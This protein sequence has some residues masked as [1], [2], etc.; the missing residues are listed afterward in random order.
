MHFSDL[1]LSEPIL[2]ALKEQKYVQATPI[3]S[4]A[5]PLI[6]QGRDALG[7]AQ[8]GTGKTAAFALPLLEHLHR[9]PQP[10]RPFRPRVLVLCPTRELAVQIAD[11]FNQY[12]A[13]LP[14]RCCMI[15]GGVNQNSQVAALKRGTEICIATPGRLLDLLGQRL[16]SLQDIHAFVLDEADRM[17]D[18]GF[19]HDI[20][21]IAGHIS[22]QRQ[23]LMFSATMPGDIRRLARELLVNPAQIEVAP[24]STPAN[25]IE[26][27]VFFVEKRHKASLLAYLYNELPMTRTIVFTRTKHGA[28]KLVHQL[29]QAGIRAEAIHS[30]KSQNARQRALNNFRS[31]KTPVLIATDIASRGIDVDQITHV[32]NFD[33]THEPETYVHRIGRTARAGASGHAISFCDK[34]ERPYLKQI[35]RLIKQQLTVRTDHPVYPENS[36]RAPTSNQVSPNHSA[37]G[38]KR[39]VKDR[40]RPGISTKHRP[41]RESPKSRYKSFSGKSRSNSKSAQKRLART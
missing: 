11:A 41:F 8:T 16:I 5:I 7:C 3:Q 31:L 23:T 15:Y 28:D 25:R 17:L 4:Q 14:V 10:A 30:N 33:L 21:R 9:N 32:V 1:M 34:D 38:G 20:R 29:H 22:S 18:M 37:S 2:R 19:I 39:P 12:G 40:S 24:A 27:S 36:D 26:Q 35:E 6:L 13:Y